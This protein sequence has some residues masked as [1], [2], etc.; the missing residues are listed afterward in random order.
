MKNIYENITKTVGRTPL[1][2]I[3][4]M[5]RGSKST[6]LVKLESFNPLSSVKDRI[7]VAMI[8]AAEREGKLGPDSVIIEP[9]SGNTGIA[10]AF[11]AAAKGYR[12]ILTMPDTFSMERRHLLKIL[13]A[14][15]VLTEGAK[16]MF[17]AVEKAE[18]LARTTK[19]GFMPQQFKNPA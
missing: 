12:L 16:G 10:L 7:G 15:L 19:N 4:R 18:E 9:T 14:K 17:G 5:N 11:A 3:N 2:K 6:I 8:E 13:G 1:V